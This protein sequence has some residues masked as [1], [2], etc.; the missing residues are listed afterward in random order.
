MKDKSFS[1]YAA[2]TAV[3]LNEIRGDDWKALRDKKRLEAMPKTF[4]GKSSKTEPEIEKEAMEEVVKRAS[5]RSALAV[6]LVKSATDI[7]MRTKFLQSLD[8]LESNREKITDVQAEGLNGRIIAERKK[9][10]LKKYG[11]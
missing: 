3:L 5:V 4:G 7:D 2:I 9:E 6:L 10:V 8:V 11:L 1:K